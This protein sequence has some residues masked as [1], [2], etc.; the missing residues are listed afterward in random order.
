MPITKSQYNLAIISNCL[1][2]IVKI[3]RTCLTPYALQQQNKRHA[4]QRG[5]QIDQ[6]SRSY[7]RLFTS[8]NGEQSNDAHNIHHKYHYRVDAQEEDLAFGAEN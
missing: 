2:N 7:E 4:H 8:R 6:S 1:V 5:E 3:K